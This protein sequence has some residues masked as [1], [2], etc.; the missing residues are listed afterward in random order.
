MTLNNQQKEKTMTK[1]KDI[2]K[3]YGFTF[4]SYKICWNKPTIV[5]T[6]PAQKGICQKEFNF[7]SRIKGDIW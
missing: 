6:A 5:V 4:I 3:K 7:C 1:L 2:A